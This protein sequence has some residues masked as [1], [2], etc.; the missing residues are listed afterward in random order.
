MQ[1]VAQ[2]DLEGL[3]NCDRVLALL[4]G[5]DPGTIF[6]IG[7][8]RAIG[9]PVTVFLTS[10]EEVNLTM[11]SGSG[12]NVLHDFVSAVYATIWSR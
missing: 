5:Y 12:C 3:R 1:N 8:A 9:M 2:A 6:E 4:D 10:T 11:F 7:Y